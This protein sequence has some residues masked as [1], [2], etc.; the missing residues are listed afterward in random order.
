[1]GEKTGRT[2]FLI[3]RFLKFR[4]LSKWEKYL[5]NTLEI[6]KDHDLPANPMELL[7]VAVDAGVR[8]S[9]CGLWVE[10]LGEQSLPKDINI[11]N[12]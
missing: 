5:T 4:G 12:A 1:L 3:I 8:L 6:L 2:L 11:E 9:A 10:I 7:K